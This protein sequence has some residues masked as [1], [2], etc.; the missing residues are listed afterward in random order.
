MFLLKKSEFCP[1]LYHSVVD[2]LHSPPH[3]QT[4]FLLDPCHIPSVSDLCIS[5]GPDL[6]SHVYYLTRTFA[7]YMHRAKM[8][9]LGRWP[10]DP[11]RK[12]KLLAKNGVMPG[13][14]VVF[15]NEKNNNSHVLGPV[16]GSSHD[17]VS[18]STHA[19]VQYYQHMNIAATASISDLPTT[20]S[21]H[22]AHLCGIPAW[23]NFDEYLPKSRI[24]RL[25]L[26][27]NFSPSLVC[28]SVSVSVGAGSLPNHNQSNVVSCLPPTVQNSQQV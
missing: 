25:P 16:D 24:S 26:L 11:G 2:V 22:G 28:S 21:T 17:A 7:Y 5:L 1:Q 18:V 15:S 20:I 27:S 23:R 19:L 14:I 6:L 3:T 10:G 4:Q 12:P 9:S 13:K 8:L